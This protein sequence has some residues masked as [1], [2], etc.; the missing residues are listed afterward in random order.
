MAE[1]LWVLEH[2][3]HPWVVSTVFFIGDRWYFLVVS[4]N[5]GWSLVR[6][7]ISTFL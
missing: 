1:S 5:K 7:K 3:E 6:L 4:I 2:P